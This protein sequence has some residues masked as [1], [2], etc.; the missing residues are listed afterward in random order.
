[1]DTP[2]QQPDHLNATTINIL[3]HLYQWFIY[4]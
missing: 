4:A 3:A 1:M 2:P